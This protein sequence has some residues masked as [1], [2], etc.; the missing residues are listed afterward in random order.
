MREGLALD[1]FQRSGLLKKA[2]FENVRWNSIKNIATQLGCDRDYA[3]LLAEVST[4]IFDS[5]INVMTPKLELSFSEARELLRYAAYLNEA[6]KLIGFQ[7]HHK[8]SYYILS[9]A[10]I[11]GF[12]R[13]ERHII[14]LSCRFSRKRLFKKS[15]LEKK[16]YLKSY[17]NTV[18]FISTC[19]RLARCLTRSRIRK[20]SNISSEL[21]GSTLTLDL[22]PLN[23][24]S[25][26]AEIASFSKEQKILSKGLH[27]DIEYNIRN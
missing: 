23:N 7:H 9:N 25:V 26:E 22:S 16:S 11:L 17:A 24:N 1:T 20:F 6:G 21:S 13:S 5:L 27:K 3:T 2:N 4:N 15:D 8:H 18:E 19:I 14:A 12:S 10:T